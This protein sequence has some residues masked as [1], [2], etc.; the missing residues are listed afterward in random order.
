[1]TFLC[2]TTGG[3]IEARD[4]TKYP[5]IHRITP[6]NKEFSSQNANSANIEK[7]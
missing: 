5:A 7:S 2:F 1:V 6:H 4:V 3:E